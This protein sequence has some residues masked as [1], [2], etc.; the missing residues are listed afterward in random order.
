MI[1][2]FRRL[3]CITLIAALGLL[4]GCGG[5]SPQK[6]TKAGL[7][8]VKF[9]TDWYAQAEHGGYYQAVAN[10]DFAAQGLDV[11]ILQGG[12][13][14]FVA[15]KVATGQVQ[16]G[17][18]R[19]DDIMLA[20]KEGLP[21]VI[22]CALMQHDPQ[23]LLLHESDP[24]NSFA[25]LN[26]RTI[27]TA[28]GAAWTEYVQK[29]FGITFNVIP[30]NYGLAQF[31]SDPTFIQQCFV[32]NEPYF[33]KQ[34]GGAA[35]TLLI[36]SSGYDPYRVIFT[37]KKFA[38]ENPAAVRAFVAASISGWDK[39]LNQDATPG[40]TLISSR[41]DKM[42]PEFI[43]FSIAA[44]KE[45]QLVGGDASRGERIGLLKRSR[46]QALSETL[47][48]LGVLPAV[49]PLEDYVSFEFLPPDLAALSQ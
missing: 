33:V 38:R 48:Q 35:K 34:N 43:D 2:P 4:S 3:S 19:S 17:M 21:V 24:A 41:N 26:G 13:G 18:G 12:P 14:A 31:M 30:I 22:V 36:A 20:V 46:M 25:D 7:T 9:Q 49:M 8:P 42:S 23:A 47:A 16:F 40:K 11:D 1:A 28:P 45:A 6:E 44:M 32:T 37:S 39:F 29:Q 15:Q 5:S 27:M 10:G